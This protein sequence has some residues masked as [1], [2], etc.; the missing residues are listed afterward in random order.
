[1]KRQFGFIHVR[2]RG[3]AKSAH[4]LFA[5]CRLINLYLHRRRLM[6]MAAA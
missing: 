1:M 3:L 6:R 4:R 5:T 2:Y